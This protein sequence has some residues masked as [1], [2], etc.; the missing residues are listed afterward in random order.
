MHV[1]LIAPAHEILALRVGGT[2]FRVARFVVG[3]PDLALLGSHRRR[4]HEFHV[5]VGHRL[6]ERHVLITR[7]DAASGII[8]EERRRF[9]INAIVVEAEVTERRRPFAVRRLML[10]HQHER[11]RLVA[12]LQ[13]VEGHV[14]DDV[15]RVTRHRDGFAVLDHRRIVVHALTGKDLP[16]VEAGRIRAEV[17]LADDR[18]LIAGLLQQLREG[19]LRTVEPGIGVVRK[20]VQVAV[21]SGEDGRT[22]RP[23]DRVRHHA[24][25]K[26]HAALGDPVDVRRLEQLPFVT[27]GADGLIRVIV[28]EDED[29]VRLAGRGGVRGQGEQ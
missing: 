16:E 10:R 1:A 27:V 17:P 12:P 9:G 29:D 13:P 28:G 11:L 7:R 20:A 25:V 14:R 26:A 6:L 2:E 18:G 5:A 21:L 24:A 3:I 15:G 8:V 19:D 4:R 23:A 22:R